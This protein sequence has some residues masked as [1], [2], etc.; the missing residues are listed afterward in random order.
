MKQTYVNYFID[1]IIFLAMLVLFVT[2]VVLWGWKR[3]T[4]PVS[5]PS[6]RPDAV[7]QARPESKPVEKA[8]GRPGDSAGDT[9][10]GAGPAAGQPQG[11]IL[12]GLFRGNSFLGMTKNGGWKSIHCWVSMLV[13]LPFM[14]LHFV[15]H[16]KW[17]LTVTAS[18]FKPRKAE[19]AQE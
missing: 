3:G 13:L 14:I 19:V 4:P 9:A 17:I 12:W 10:K 11:L 7:A 15:M 5:G 8:E 16:L 6:A 18:F 1:W 2:G